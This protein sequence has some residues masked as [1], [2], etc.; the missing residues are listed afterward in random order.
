M[1][2]S[3]YTMFL[4]TKPGRDFNWAAFN[5]SMEEA[6][7]GTLDLLLHVAQGGSFAPVFQGKRKADNFV[8]AQYLGLDFDEGVPLSRLLAHPCIRSYAGLIYPTH[9]YTPDHPRYRVVIPLDQPIWSAEGYLLALRTIH[10]IFPQADAACVDVSRLFFGNARIEK[11]GMWELCYQAD[12]HM[13]L[14]DLR[15]YAK[16]MLR[17]QRGQQRGQQEGQQPRHKAQGGITVD[18]TFERLASIDPYAMPYDEWFK[19]GC[20]IAH[21]FGEFAY[22]RFKSWSD[23]PGHDPLTVKKWAE[24]CKSHQSPAGGGTIV[25]TILKYEKGRAA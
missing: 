2:I 25:S 22:A 15:C 3:L 17:Q 16:R 12:A 24:M 10:H 7:I 9:S 1:L 23:R 6:D 14:A 8:C 5:L 21:T 13:P 11:E 19:L 4:D 20:A 18:E